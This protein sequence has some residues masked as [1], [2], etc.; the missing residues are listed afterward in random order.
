MAFLGWAAGTV[1]F[2][3]GG[4]MALYCNVKLAR[5]AVIDGKRYVRFRDISY[6]VFGRQSEQDCR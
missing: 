1:L 3:A 5:L 4:V 6:A 2:L